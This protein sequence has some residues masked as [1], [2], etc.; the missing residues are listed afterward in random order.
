MF[1]VHTIT[2][3]GLAL[4]AFGAVELV[5]R[6]LIRRELLEQPERPRVQALLRGRLK[7]SDFTDRDRRNVLIGNALIVSAAILTWI[8]FGFIT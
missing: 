3:F 7:H 6:S 2:Y 8:G 1:I 4:I 5:L